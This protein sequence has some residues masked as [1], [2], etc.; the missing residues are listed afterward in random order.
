MSGGADDSAQDVMERA[1]RRLGILEY[2]FLGLAA[3][4]AL[5]AGALVGWLLQQGLGW[6]FRITWATT[7][8]LLFLVPGLFSWWRVRQDERRPH[9]YRNDA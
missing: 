6:S 5:V 7:S 2:L 4:G 1:I 3:V 8:L 9:D